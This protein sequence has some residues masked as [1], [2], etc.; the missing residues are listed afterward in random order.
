MNQT[1][2]EQST[3]KAHDHPEYSPGLEGVI[4]G[5]SAICQVDEGE[6]GL[7]YRGYA[8][9]D[10]AGRSS[11][12]EVA[13]LLL[14]GH[15]PATTEL[16]E[17]SRLLVRNR[18]LPQQVHHFVGDHVV[19]EAHRRL[20]DPPVETDDTWA[21]PGAHQGI[22]VVLGLPSVLNLYLEGFG[23]LRKSCSI[24]RLKG[25]ATVLGAE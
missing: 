21:A 12:E 1:M 11:F 2:Q 13:Y 5:E 19:H 18:R 16:E 3:V 20:N 10:L 4:A 9:G 24:Q 6:A 23:Q 15:L 17:F 25:S 8:I 22:N 7:R 14:F